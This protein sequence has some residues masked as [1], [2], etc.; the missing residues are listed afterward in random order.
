MSN[1]KVPKAMEE[2][3]NEISKI[4]GEFCNE[5]LNHEYETLSIDL[6]AAL[7]RKRPSPL[8]KGRAKTW[9]CAIVHAIGS[10]NFLFDPEQEPHM[11]AK[12]LYLN[13]GVSSSSGGTKSREIQE[14]MD[15]NFFNGQWT[16]PSKLED[17]PMIWQLSVNGLIIDV[18]NAPREIQEEAFRQG[19]IPYIPADKNKEDKASKNQG[20]KIIEFPGNKAKSKRKK[21]L[22]ERERRELADEIISGVY[23]CDYADEAIELAKEALE[24]YE[25]CSQAYIV[26]GD[27]S[28][29]SNLERKAYFQKAVE[30][31][32]NEL[33]KEFEELKGHFWLAHETRPYM[34]AKA[35][36]AHYLWDIGH[37]S[38][39]IKEAK[40]MLQLNPNDNQGIRWLIV[41]WLIL[42]NDSY[43]EELLKVYEDDGSA[44]IIFSKA[45]LEFKKGNKKEAE[46][47]L[48][49]AK[50]YNPHV[51]PYLVG[52]KKLPKQPPE[53][54]GIGDDLEA[55]AYVFDGGYEA[56]KNTEGAIA[57][58]KTIK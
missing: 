37:R 2:K 43:I 25:N 28:D 6:C 33:G 12:D 27:V 15:V 40:E 24:V 26:L 5:H 32:K 56:W 22:T 49:E 8:E 16:L 34:M 1:R 19:L 3:F 29:C 20:S 13:F 58:I 11:K 9:A 10:A 41:N 50:K 35:N 46:K 17:N 54:M 51:I 14:L 7:C 47:H 44:S 23:E 55:Q 52:K 4:I 45:L 48:K 39:A 57:W 38:E 18:R 36:L 42:E 31:A 21:S 53:Y 30:A